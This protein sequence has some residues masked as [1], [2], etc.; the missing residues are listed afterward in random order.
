ME[1]LMTTCMKLSDEIIMEDMRGWIFFLSI[2]SV[3]QLHYI[4]FPP[5]P[6]KKNHI[7]SGL[8]LQFLLSLKTLLTLVPF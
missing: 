3:K 2:K 7:M 6:P 1:E 4:T 8:Q 5:P